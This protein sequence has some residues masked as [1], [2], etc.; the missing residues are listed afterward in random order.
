M[1]AVARVWSQIIMSSPLLVMGFGAHAITEALAWKRL[2]EMLL[3]KALLETPDRLSVSY[4]GLAVVDDPIRRA[5]V[6]YLSPRSFV[7]IYTYVVV[8][9]IHIDT[10]G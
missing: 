1:L 7:L 8:M 10:L 9:Y 4:V 2:A 6:S 3:E 5:F